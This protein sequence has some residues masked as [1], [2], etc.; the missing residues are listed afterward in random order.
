MFILC[1][2]VIVHSSTAYVLIQ[3]TLTPYLGSL[4]N[5]ILKPKNRETD[6]M[7]NQVRTSKVCLHVLCLSSSLSLPVNC[8]FGPIQTLNWLVTGRNLYKNRV[9]KFAKIAL[10]SLQNGH[11]SQKNIL[12]TKYCM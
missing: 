10:K 12:F 7:A 1:L 6:S 5:G 2:V 3:L 11:R 9:K 4:H 8:I